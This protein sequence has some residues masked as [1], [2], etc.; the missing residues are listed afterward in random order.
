MPAE[1]PWRVLIAEDQEAIREILVLTFSGGP[2]EIYSA[3]DGQK[4]LEMARQIH[5]HLVITDLRM[6]RMDGLALARA[7]RL[8]PAMAGVPI[9]VVTALAHPGA[10]L[11][12]YGAGA[13][14]FFV[15]P[16][17]PT[18]LRERAEHLLQEAFPRP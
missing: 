7:L 8:D 14:A 5:P 13:N 15:K 6:P 4:A 16:F 18:A 1:G 9:I 17:S 3:R 10:E 2:F 12:A 11:Q